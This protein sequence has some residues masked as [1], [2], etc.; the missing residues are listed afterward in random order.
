M[1]WQVEPELSFGKL[2]LEALQ[3]PQRIEPLRAL[4]DE[5]LA[6][7]PDSYLCTVRL[8]HH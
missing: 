1:I 7:A 2:L 3:L 4:D 5:W 8:R 6:L